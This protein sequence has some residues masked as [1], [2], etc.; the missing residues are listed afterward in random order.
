[1]ATL[2]LI[3]TPTNYFD[4]KKLAGDEV[5][6]FSILKSFYSALRGEAAVGGLE[7]PKSS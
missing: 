5:I 6:H 2:R 3:F 7:Y 4:I 1:M